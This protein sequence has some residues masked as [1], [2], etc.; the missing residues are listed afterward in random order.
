MIVR[1]CY[2]ICCS[3]YSSPWQPPYNSVRYWHSSKIWTPNKGPSKTY[4]C[5]L[6]KTRGGSYCLLGETRD[7]SD[8]GGTALRRPLSTSILS[9]LLIPHPLSKTL[10]LLRTSK[11]NGAA[12]FYLYLPTVFP[13]PSSLNI[14]LF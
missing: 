6:G 3:K 11:R 10:T 8:I 14:P 1:C 13:Y 9:T 2:A 7:K 12:S 5:L 4:Y